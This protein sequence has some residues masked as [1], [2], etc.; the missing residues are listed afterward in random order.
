VDKKMESA[1]RNSF[2]PLSKVCFSM[3]RFS[4]KSPSHNKFLWTS[5]VLN[6]KKKNQMK[7]VENGKILIY[8]TKKSMPFTE[9]IVTELKLDKQCFVT[10]SYTKLLEL[11]MQISWGLILRH[12]E[13]YMVSK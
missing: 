5:P 6:F 9:L 10:N 13:M 3:Y 11:L 4:Q 12:E 2:M 7:N 8:T 1:D